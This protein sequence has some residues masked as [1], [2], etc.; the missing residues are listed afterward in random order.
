MT[1]SRETDGMSRRGLLAGVA[2]TGL[3]GIW[4]HPEATAWEAER[5]HDSLRITG[6]EL[7]PVRLP[8]NRKWLFLRLV[9]NQG[10]SGIAEATLGGTDK[11]SELKTFFGLIDG[12]SPFDI[13]RYREQGLGLAVTGGRKMA[14]AFSAIEQALWDLVGKT[15]NVPVYDLFG[16][17]LRDQIDVYANINNATIDRSPAGFAENAAQAVGEGFLALKAAPFD[18]FPA[19]DASSDEIERATTTGVDCIGA[20]RKT[21]GD[22]V[23]LKVDFH[24]YFDVERTINVAQRIAPFDLS[25]IEEPIDAQDVVGTS[26]IQKVIPQRLAGGEFLVGL[27]QF[28]PLCR[29]ECVEVLMPDVQICGGLLEGQRIATAAELHGQTVAPHNAHGPVATAASAQLSAVLPNFEILEYQ[30]NEV[31]WRAEL[32]NPPEAIHEGRIHL[33]D[34]AGFGVELNEQVVAAHI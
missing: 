9:T 3:A 26:Q 10:I 5:G 30:W 19:L 11:V 8:R 16:G 1:M 31:P 21:A 20:I 29:T 32:I 6:L 15:L 17:K 22:D 4:Y 33:N 2:T 34:R 28:G 18:G 25:W 7:F 23:K 13:R 14:G 12:A 27:H 24:S